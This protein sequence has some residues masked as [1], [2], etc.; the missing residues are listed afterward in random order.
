MPIVDFIPF[1]ND[2]SAANVVTQ[3]AYLAAASGSGYVQNGFPSSR[4]NSNS[5]NKA[6][7]QSSVMVAS[8]AQ[9]IAAKTGSDVLDSGGSTAITTL[10][11]LIAAAVQAEIDASTTAL[12]LG[13]MSTQNSTSVSITGGTIGSSVAFDIFPTGT[14][15]LF[16]QT[17]AP[18]GWTKSGAHNDKML[19]I[20]SGSAGS[21]GSAALSTAWS[22]VALSGSVAGHTL[23]VTELP[24]HT[25]S[26][27]TGNDSPDH[28]HT[29]TTRTQENEGPSYGG[30]CW[31]GSQTVSSGGASARHQHG[32]TTD[33][34]TGGGAS[35]AHGLTINS[36]TVT[37]A[38][39]DAI[40]CIRN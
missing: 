17:A 36:F 14:A 15:M 26:G 32:F 6:W 2:P 1:A 35:H 24:S 11:A 28:S 38:Y 30:L 21:G 8:I 20:V 18:T 19:R 4:A 10:T 22:S 37:P 23:S 25:H 39:V 12:G 7:R 34:G 16:A 33:G 13:S 5:A 29:Y 9:W 40:I 31:N 3:A 27:T